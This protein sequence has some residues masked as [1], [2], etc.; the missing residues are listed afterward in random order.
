MNSQ[1]NAIGYLHVRLSVPTPKSITWYMCVM[2]DK[3]QGSKREHAC[4]HLEGHPAVKDNQEFKRKEISTP[5]SALPERGLN[6][7]L[8]A[9]TNWCVHHY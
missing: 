4:N 5:S 1:L 6:P 7:R 3:G 2:V 9:W 8:S